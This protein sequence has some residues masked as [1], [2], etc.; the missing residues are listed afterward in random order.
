MTHPRTALV[1]WWLLLALLLSTNLST[2]L[3]EDQTHLDNK[4]S[5][6]SNNREKSSDIPNIPEL[7]PK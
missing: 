5:S 6:S 7:S 2:V 4:V 1:M 3:G